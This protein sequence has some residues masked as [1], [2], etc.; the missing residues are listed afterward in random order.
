[1]DLIKTL[2]NFMMIS[3]LHFFFSLNIKS[4]INMTLIPLSHQAA[5]HEGPLQTVDGSLF[6][7]PSQPQE[8]EF[9]NQ[10]QNKRMKINDD[11]P[12]GDSLSDWIPEYVGV[13]YPGL[14]NDLIQQSNG[15]IDEKT[16][17]KATDTLEI[18]GDHKQY[19]ILKNCLYGYSQPS[20][21]DIKLG[22]ILY[23]SS[24]NAS[25][26]ERMKK[27]SQSTTSG[28]LKF[29]IA[30]MVIKDS[31]DGKLPEDLPGFKMKDVSSTT[32][33]KDYITFD[34]YFGRKLTKDTVSE[35]LKIFFRYNNLPKHVQDRLIENFHV[36][37]QMLYNC[38]L[39]EEIRVISGSLF[40]VFENDLSRWEAKNYEDPIIS[41]PTINDDDEDEDEGDED[42]DEETEHTDDKE[43]DEDVPLSCLK[44]IDFAH[45]KY[46][47][48]EGYDEEL[49]SGIQNLFEI[50][51]NI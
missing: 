29:R 46:T 15:A 13:L 6:I 36:R 42:E 3:F 48:S 30:G 37:L 40:F 28:S 16:L 10:T 35:G 39:E 5:G 45:A 8:I 32:F 21:L 38:L 18:E 11:V 51:E 22:S 2:I 19:L 43:L 17:N 44:F 24:A 23:D 50:I 14:S 7:K 4:F 26:V 47:P 12:Y 1:M 20:I 34:K 27:V 9:Y 31:F 25:K 49:V 41:T 33:K